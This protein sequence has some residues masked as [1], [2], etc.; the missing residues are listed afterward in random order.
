MSDLQTAPIKDFLLGIYDGPHA[1]PKEADEGPIFLGIKNVT[2]EGR[3]DLTEIRH[4]SEQEFPKWTKRVSPQKD[5]V[6]FSYEATLHRYA[7]IPE[8]F[9]GCLGRRM[10]LVRPD[11]GK[12]IPRFLHYYFMSPAWKAGVLD[13]EPKYRLSP[14][15]QC[16]ICSTICSVIQAEINTNFIFYRSATMK[17]QLT[18]K[19]GWDLYRMTILASSKK[20]ARLQKLVD[21]T[22]T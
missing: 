12:I 8:G 15:K 5:D 6:V 9:H 2:P 17:T 18:I 22:N 4:V 11:Q 7:L 1:T 10:A 3:L 20:T 16:M 21:G 19:E 13:R 14:N